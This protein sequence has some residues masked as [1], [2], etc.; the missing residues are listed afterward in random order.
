MIYFDCNWLSIDWVIDCIIV[1]VIIMC[2]NTSLSLTLVIWF[3]DLIKFYTNYCAWGSF[4]SKHENI[5]DL[6]AQR[7]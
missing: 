7:Q 4:I 2:V 6:K 5:F 1:V 3:H